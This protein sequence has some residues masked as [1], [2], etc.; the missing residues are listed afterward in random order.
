VR[1][2]S[3][4]LQL[5]ASLA[6]LAL[7]PAVARGFVVGKPPAPL[8]SYSIFGNARSTGA[9]LMLPG[10]V[11]AE[12]R[13]VLLTSAAA[14][15]T[16]LPP[17]A[18]IE[19]AYVF[20][21]GSLAQN[22]VTGP[23]VADP[24]VN[25]TAATG[26]SYLV[27]AAPGD[28][29][30]V[31][32]P[33]LGTTYPPFY[34][35]RAEVTSQVVPNKV[36]GAYNGTY[37]VGGVDADPGHINGSGQC[38]EAYARCQAKYAAWS[39]VVIYSSP[40][41]TLQRDIHLYDGFLMVDHEDGPQGSLGVTS[42][43]IGNFL[44]DTT[45]QGTLSY[46]A[47]E[48]DKQLGQPPQ[49][50]Y[51][52]GNPQYCTTC[53]D[54]VKFNGSTLV[55]DFGWPGNI[56]NESLAS[57]VDI[58]VID[59]SSLI[60]PSSTSAVIEIGSGTGPIVQPEPA[61]GGGELFGFGWTLLS[62]RRPAPNFKTAGTNKSVNPIQA[63][64]GETLAYT[65]NVLNAGSLAATS[66]VVSDTLPADVNYKP[67]SLQVSGVPCTDA[68]DG[69]PCT[70][71]GKTLTI[72]LGTLP[73]LPPTN[74][75]QI[76]FLAT[77][78]PSAT[79]GQVICNQAAIT[80][81][82]TP[83][84]YSTAPSCLTVKAPELNTPT[85][86]VLDL[87][88][89]VV[90]P[91]DI[92]QFTVT[93][94]AKGTGPISGI[95]FTDDM[96][97]Y[98]QLLTVI[99]PAGATDASSPTGGVNGRGQVKVS[100]ITIP[101]AV[102]SVAV[103]FLA[104]IDSAATLA[105]QGVPPG[106]IEGK[107]LC[108]QGT[109]SAA[110]LPAPL[111]T[112][113]PAVVGTSNATC[114][115]LTYSPSLSTSSKSVVDLNGGK[116]EPGDTLRYTLTFVNTGNRNA[117]LTIT[118][119]MPTQV[120]G[121]ALVGAVPGATF[122]PPPAGA[123]GTGRLTVAGFAVPAGETRT[124]QFEVTVIAA[125]TNNAVVQNCTS[126]TVA[127]KASENGWRCSPSLSIYATP[128][129]SGA[130]KTV[131]DVNGGSPQPGDTLRYTVAIPNSGNR[132]AT[133]VNVSDVVS[134]TLT[135]VTPLDGGTYDAA[136]RTITW[137][138]GNVAKGAT[139]TVRFDAK[140]V[141]P[142]PN[143]T[144]LC[145]QASVSSAELPVELTDN[146]AT[147]A[148]NDATCVTV[149]SKPDLSAMTKVVQD[150]NGAPTR[151]GD[152]LRYTITFRNDGTETATAV[153]V[154]DVVSTL[155]TAVVPLDG[156]VYDAATRTVSWSIASLAPT[157]QQIVRFEATVV[158]P[159]VNGTTIS[160]QAFVTA[161]Q[162]P[163][164]GTPSDD[165]A[166]PALDD[167]TLITIT[168]APKLD[169]TDKTVLDVNGGVPQP[170]DVMSYALTVRNT[171]D[172]PARSTIVTDVVSTNLTN[173]VPLDGGVYNP[174]NRTLTWL[175]GDVVPGTDKVL[176]F[177]A[178][179]VLPLAN[180]TAVCNQGSAKTQ[181][182]ATAVPTDDP[183]T[184]AVDDATCVTVQSKPDLGPSTK[185]VEDLNGGKV[186][187][188]DTL[189]YTIKIDNIGTQNATGVVAAD[190]VSAN[191]TNVV[192]LDGGT[193]S[194]ATRTIT[195]NVGQVNAKTAATVRF[196]AQVVIPLDD[197]TKIANQG[198]ITA[199]EIPIPVLTDDPATPASHDPT[200]VTVSATPVFSTSTK[201]VLDVNGGKV[202]P[203][204]TLSYTLT[205][206][207]SGTSLADKVLVTDAVDPNVDFVNAGQGGVYNATTRTV[208][209]SNATT[210]ALLQVA[211][212]P[213][214]AVTLTFAVKVKSPMANGTPICNQA[215][216]ASEELTAAQKTDNPQT[217]VVGDATCVTVFSAPDLS[218]TSKTVNDVNGLPVRPGHV[219]SYAISIPNTGNAPATNVIVTD[220]VDASLTSVTVGQGG[221]Y[222]ALTRTITW[223]A[224]TT[225]GL[226]S[227]APGATMG[228]T[229]SATVVKPLDGG[230]KI[231]NQASL[232]S[233]EL[234]VPVLSDDP[235]T[236]TIDDPT[237]VT[238][239]ATPDLVGSTKTVVDPNGG[240]VEPGDLLN[241]TLTLRNSGD[242]VA[243][244]VVVSDVV[245]V[246]LQN[247]VV[248]DGG[249]Y[250]AA[251]RT[252]TWNVPLVPL[253]PAGDVVL[254]FTAQVVTPLKNATKISNQGSVKVGP[255]PAVL[256]DD[257]KT[258]A[259]GDPTVVVVA[260]KPNLSEMTKT[261]A[262]ALP[263]KKVGPG[264]LLTYT[265]SLPNTGTEDAQDLVVT[266]VVDPSLEA[267]V[268]LDGGTYNGTTRTISWKI[269]S[270]KVG[271]KATLRFSAQVKADV[272][273]GELISNQAFAELPGQP[274]VP[275]D[276]PSTPQLDDPTVLTIE[277][278]ANVEDFTKSVKDLNGGD[279][280]PGDVLEYTLVV[281][282][283]GTAY[284][285]N[286]KVTDPAPTA[287][288]TA[289]T[290]GQ[291][292]TF[293][294]ATGAVTW[295]GSTT[296]SLAK[297]APGGAVTLSFTA[298]VKVPTANGTIISN[299]AQVGGTGV[300]EPSDDPSTPEKND[301]TVVKVV[302]TPR[303]SSSEKRV[304]DLNGGQVK[305]GEILEYTIK[306]INN[307]TANAS[308]VTLI[309]PV[310]TYSTYIAGS[311][312]LNGATVPDAAGG[313]SPLAKGLLVGTL[314]QPPGVVVVGEA[315]AAEIR[316]RVRVRFETQEGSIISNQGM[317]T[318][319]QT[320]LAVTDDPTTAVKGDPTQV[321]VG[322]GP[323][324]NGTTKA[325]S[326]K[327][328]GDNGNGRF[329]V[330]EGIA[331]T[332]T[333]PNT[334]SA[335]A[336]GV[337]YTD[338]LDPNGRLAYSKA[339]LTLNGLTLSDPADGDAGAVQGNN[340]RVVVGT[341]E[342]GKSAVITYQARIVSGPRVSN[343]GTVRSTELQPELTDSDGNEGN[344][345]SPTVVVVQG[346]PGRS[347]RGQK[348][349]QDINGGDVRAG[350]EMLY[351]ITVFNDGTSDETVDVIDDVPANALYVAQSLVAPPGTNPQ[352][353]P[354]PAGQNKR[355]RVLV[356]TK[357]KA[358]ESASVLL[359]L[360]LD[361]TLL[362]GASV[363]NAVRL[364]GD[365]GLDLQAPIDPSCVLIGSPAGTGGLGGVVFRD[366]GARNRILD[367]KDQRLSSFQVQAFAFGNPN[368]TPV[369]SAVSDDKGS[370]RI[371]ALPP[372][373]YTLR[374]LSS[375]GVQM[376]A[377]AALTV[378]A[379]TASTQNLPVDP[380]GVVYDAVA[381][382][383]AP[384]VQAFLYYDE[385]DGGAPSALVPASLLG[386]GQQGQV[387][388]GSGFYR[389]DVQP[390][391]RYQ[392][393]LQPLSPSQQFPSA[394][395][396]VTPGFAVV[397]ADHRVV[398]DDVPD[399]K[400]QGAKLSYFL[401]LKVDS[402][403]DEVFNNHIPVD[404]LSSLIRLEKRADKTRA[405]LGDLVTYT[406]TAENRST[407]E[408]LAAGSQIAIEDVLPAGLR[409]L[410]GTGRMI[411]RLRAGRS[412]LGGESATKDVDGSA[413]CAL[414][415][416]PTTHSG[417]VLRFGPF[418]LGAGESL[419]LLYRVA[420][421][422]DTRQGTY[423]NRAVLRD[424]SFAT[425]L[426]NVA[427]ARLLVVPDP[428]LDQGLLLG[429]VFCDANGD[430]RVSAGERG[431]PNARVYL[432][433]GTYAVTDETGKYH[434][435]NIDP[436]LHLLKLDVDTLPVGSRTTTAVARV[437]QF[438]R[439]LPAKVD[440]G[441]TCRE[442][443]IKVQKIELKP[444]E[445]K[446][447]TAAPR[448][449]VVPATSL[450]GDARELRLSVDGRVTSLLEADLALVRAGGS[451]VPL[452]A[453]WDG[454][455]L[456]ALRLDLLGRLT[457]RLVINLRARH[458]PARGW[459]LT[460][461][462]VD[463][464]G[465]QMVKRFSGEGQPPEQVVWDGLSAGRPVLAGGKLYEAQLEVIAF[466]GAGGSSPYR[467]FT[468]GWG[469]R[470]PPARGRPMAPAAALDGAP[471]TLDARH[472]FA[473]VLGR[474][475]ARPPLLELR[476]GDGKATW[477]P[478]GEVVEPEEEPHERVQVKGSLISG[479]LIVDNK[480][481]DTSLLAIS[482]AAD[483]EG[484][485]PTLGRDGKLRQPAQLTAAAAAI[486]Q[487]WVLR[488]ADPAGRRQRAISGAG[489]VPSPLTWDGLDD[490]GQPMVEPGGVYLA[491]LTLHDAQ[492]NLGHST[493]ATLT[494]PAAVSF[495]ALKLQGRQLF[496]ART[497]ALAA[498]SR[499]KLLEVLRTI[500]K[501]PASER[502]RITVRVAPPVAWESER[503]AGLLK[504]VQDGL[505]ATL[506][507]SG[508]PAVRCE[509][510]V[511]AQPLPSSLPVAPAAPRR[512]RAAQPSPRIIRLESL[513]LDAVPPPPVA[514]APEAARVMID[515][516]NVA[517]KKDGS[518]ATWAR[519]QLGSA[520]LFDLRDAVGHRAQL[521]VPTT[522]RSRLP[523]A[524][525]PGSRL[526]QL[527]APRVAS[528]GPTGGALLLRMRGGETVRVRL[529]QVDD[530]TPGEAR[531]TSTPAASAPASKP[532]GAPAATTAGRRPATRDSSR[533]FG[534]EVLR[535]SFGLPPS[536]T[537][538]E[539]GPAPRSVA[540]AQL[541]VDLPPQGSV[542]KA[543]ELAL[544]GRTHPKNV[545]TINGQR[546]ELREDGSFSHVVKLPVGK[547]E[548][549]IRALDPQGNQGT[550]RWPVEVSSRAF[551]LMAMTEGAIGQVGV[552]LDGENDHTRLAAGPVMLHGRAVLYLK[553][554]IQGKFLFKNYFITAHVD[555]AK[556]REFQ[557]FFDQVIDP[558]RF[559][560][561]YGDSAKEIRD[562]NARDKYYL[563][564]EADR[565][566]LLL[567]NFTA[568]VKGLELLR[569]DRMLYGVKVD[570]DK[571][572]FGGKLRQQAKV[573][574]SYDDT[575]LTRDHNVLRSTGGS[576]YYLRHGQV[577][578]G[579]ERVNVVVRERDT[580]L[581][582]ATLAKGR[583]TD[584]TV[585]YA[586]GRLMFKTPVP[587]V[588]DATFS[589]ANPTFTMSTL[590][591]HPVYV[592]VDYEYERTD[593][594]GSGAWGFQI[595]DTLFDVLTLGASYVREDRNA[596]AGASYQL[597]G[598]EMTL[599]HGK[600]SSVTAEY[601]HSQSFDAQN[602]ISEDGGI[603][604]LAMNQTAQ[605]SADPRAS[606]SNA[607][608]ITATLELSDFIKRVRPEAFKAHGY[609][610]RLDRG[611][612]SDGTI[613][614][615]GRT[616]YGGSLEWTITPRDKVTVRHDGAIALLPQIPLPGSKL[617]P[618]A[619]R[620]IETELTRV[621]YDLQR[622]RF[623]LHGE[624]AHSFLRDPV[625][626]GGESNRDSIGVL[627]SYQIHK[628]LRVSLGQDAIVYASGRD[629]Q[630][631]TGALGMSVVDSGDWRNRLMTTVG[632]TVTLTK[633]LDL[634]LA[635]SVRW[636]GDNSTAAGIKVQLA[637]NASIYARQLLNSTDSRL[638]TTSIVGAEDRFGR[639]LN[640]RTYGEY[641]IE[642][643]ISGVQNRAIL[644][645][646]HKWAAWR[647]LSFTGG[648]EHQ[649]IFGGHLPDGT[650]T[651]N[652][653]R[654][655]VHVGVE[656]TRFR[657]LKLSTHAELR[658]DNGAGVMG[659][660]PGQ[661]ST[662][663]APNVDTR[664]GL[665]AGSYADR[666]VTPGS[667]LMLSPGERW[668]IV[669]RTGISWAATR[670]ITLLGRA[671]LY[672]TY[673]RTQGRLE[674][675]ALELGVGAALRPVAWDWLNV[676]FKYTHLQEMRPLS[677]TDDLSQWR[678]YDI[679][680]VVPIVE[681]PFRFQLVEKLAYKRV[682]EEQGIVPGSQLATVVHT[683]LWINRVNFHLTGRIDAGVEY[684]ML[685]L[686]IP[687]QGDQ[688][689]HGVLVELGYWVHEYV[690]LGAGWNFTSFS[691]NE[692]ADQSRDA[693]GFFFRAVGKY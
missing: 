545:V 112:D 91:D 317:I 267:V 12:I 453:S 230:T 436:G 249:V 568:G 547:S 311:T 448:R 486:I 121:F 316:F 167:P 126:Y 181:D 539:R 162:I 269:P 34:Y 24:T 597:Y 392:I 175:A 296:P 653:Q 94:P 599:R 408:F 295:D 30:T 169:N 651:G 630:L 499:R 280:E 445:T 463:E 13:S 279:V 92:L 341:I 99:P 537:K 66:T 47:V 123:N 601:A 72:N 221:V 163:A 416:N 318:S 549:T 185:T 468:V 456:A 130:S 378:P 272:K 485:L 171:G 106:A 1:T 45:P 387:T 304:T 222:N 100:D 357:I 382:G 687:D 243:K 616:K 498:P 170:G 177:S 320:A 533:P 6:L 200:V 552:E 82:Q 173:V 528:G 62:L 505:T 57:G 294:A 70:V 214:A 242:A 133:S 663:V 241:W 345:D 290:P 478:L 553:G 140:I 665:G 532:S 608:K 210:P 191:L 615:Q 195:W 656:L 646:D 271:G 107:T 137:A 418:P 250:N 19:K 657:K 63:G 207:N 149:V 371:A 370:F 534:D 431:V 172:A 103:T 127:E 447:P 394:L 417:R 37:I 336:T 199:T 683:L 83:V 300:S 600:G 310:P 53:Q 183:T 131:L 495:T 406:L 538:D 97:A 77:V 270:L 607:Y 76:T 661:P 339:T 372:G 420:V 283:S 512:R 351:T 65:V 565:S 108:N 405:S 622:G 98:L 313:T 379:G 667:Q 265:I 594:K 407:R 333:I 358:G 543:T 74:S 654:D 662:V 479:Q 340:I 522:P 373:P 361:S 4:T 635:E 194:T 245:D 685:R 232:S 509:L 197:G 26:L 81:T 80:S 425:D 508:L 275:S 368:A 196:T 51:P 67:N 262:G 52:P 467:R 20:W 58:D 412:C 326:P 516:E 337:V 529:A 466:G 462:R 239:T 144:V 152:R 612:Y 353:E 27:N 578:V 572:F 168:S 69:D 158:T 526:Q 303:F 432:D 75:R 41:E 641:Q 681:L 452:G 428:E 193:F 438:T 670:D 360:V 398:S 88:G 203:G 44:A 143:N 251:T 446:K 530:R 352:I 71:S 515:G 441:A 426:S 253:T 411:R 259:A 363:C 165:P 684:R 510:T 604:Y 674:A 154:R 583:D 523:A 449:L 40:S 204:D 588:A 89:G 474:L 291:G 369:A 293:S 401:R 38:T 381:G 286:L 419:R 217:P 302:S 559:Y 679:L 691:D 525:P 258:P 655:V 146:P 289:I 105:Q 675:Q 636:T 244:A 393:K 611:F 480:T 206:V 617:D 134:T 451:V 362:E 658:Y 278:V 433:N 535:E 344:G 49:N 644:G 682:A 440:F 676:L 686:F 427:E 469:H 5:L 592:E 153:L 122:I 579:S 514:V 228:L 404:P 455:P 626:A 350:D 23:K 376:G 356:S 396:P 386:H 550:I 35:C 645:L 87:N 602:F 15:L 223:S 355:G 424:S 120:T 442:N 145:N 541:E 231:A 439:G 374:V 208:T 613:L 10:P 692:F 141:I 124:I 614:E 461:W 690:R 531:P 159:L 544:R 129:L 554:R 312:L 652:A 90:A 252:I 182:L 488:I 563:L 64:Q 160:N 631:G 261:V 475:S 573:F 402:K 513:Y 500:R 540:A 236:T 115:T 558:N 164:P 364:G 460:I 136:T 237:V 110:F 212:G 459:H 359:R 305:P 39:M 184:P 621:R 348:T 330:G 633:Y 328:V 139:A 384:N 85:K 634:E 32:H 114:K 178:S 285:F 329:D 132:P 576:I 560:P 342:P 496:D 504:A 327:P 33:T 48:T 119:D 598:G 666:L 585:D 46:F 375:K 309:D 443:W 591:G 569:Y 506:A 680:S 567:G 220:V 490:K 492:G 287:H 501:R 454:A 216:L 517:V 257:P 664:P 421:G 151:P 3:A 334:G 648:Y 610:S 584:Y 403:S 627:A 319:L 347:L 470:S 623:R 589:V 571:D 9:T 397:D 593:S 491:R 483:K 595:K 458:R 60:P 135:S 202:E 518:F 603:S 264:T 142:T 189:R 186:E 266:D 331:Y 229:F 637:K 400:K 519:V 642:S 102:T 575:R 577:V 79:N 562:V 215:L 7:L 101:P 624:Y 346:G 308:G 489:P 484:Q 673:N 389:F 582:L 640:G 556:Q 457:P 587:S 542:I 31:V 190:V 292:G 247:V 619:M 211:L 225:P 349:A 606:D 444:Q 647:G 11:A 688:L 73:Y 95:S 434:L 42:F 314:G 179:I 429:R 586:G 557:D 240:D 561:V 497:G 672:R 693:S 546:V 413:A 570:F 524:H 391:R 248:L 263:S 482:L 507:T 669:S 128:D 423:I 16:G 476:R 581:L 276:D 166:T 315:A 78:A 22:G 367:E 365:A 629:P 639:A 21:S 288:L 180:G 2:R 632:A 260:S 205:I 209:W 574:V 218:N 201:A 388:D 54:Y 118:D 551:F 383:A 472:R 464:G 385:T 50:L 227:L 86:V 437:V 299:Q 25:F 471:L 343:Q 273:N 502:Y 298:Q 564:V 527:A 117:T 238:V 224:A 511:G 61:N 625:T 430:G 628:R 157:Q 155:L 284:A 503:W 125:A 481:I 435:R 536:V 174:T 198:S 477:L 8:A 335:K 415:T 256:T 409:L 14:S 590:A 43:A 555:T 678:T 324:L 332:V 620:D 301:P 68:A 323:N 689:R 390:G 96:P 59:V 521:L 255:A 188:G 671:N 277:A 366:L 187:P 254:R 493:L 325:Y 659:L 321:V 36:G 609:Y 93:I 677:L 465:R 649:Q 156:G 268:A 399:P 29:T 233:A 147:L 281:R 282:N 580:G 306:V 113:D 56:F 226:A 660:M 638:S 138:V 354:P 116:L 338:A 55:D 235:T 650:P 28:C 668:Q 297:L 643:G 473:T 548:L 395:I 596:D 380:S 150:L 410:N 307:G 161:T 422:L 111:P 377:E 487:R 246:N 566:S 520:L 17:D 192:P 148:T 494:A 18:I 322:S 213:T 450:A 605:L 176:R 274:K 219:L 104:R 414:S 234:P 84:P 618:L 109:I